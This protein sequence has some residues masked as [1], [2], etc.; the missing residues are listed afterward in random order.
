MVVS[1][2]VVDLLRLWLGEVSRGKT[3]GRWAVPLRCE[4]VVES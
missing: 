4:R 2:A 3:R 1:L